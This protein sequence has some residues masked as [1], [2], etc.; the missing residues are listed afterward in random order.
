MPVIVVSNSVA[1]W[2]IW[3]PAEYHPAA[4]INT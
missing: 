3:G 4:R 2:M 1:L